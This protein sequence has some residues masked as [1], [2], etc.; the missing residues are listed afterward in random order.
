VGP[1]KLSNKSEGEGQSL[2]YHLNFLSVACW[3]KLQ[4]SMSLS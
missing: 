2:A 1:D 3:L 4:N